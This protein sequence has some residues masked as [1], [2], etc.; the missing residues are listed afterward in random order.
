MAELLTDEII[1]EHL[2]NDDIM[3]EPDGPWI[4][5]YMQ[6]QYGGKLDNTSDFVDDKWTLKIYSEMTYDGYDI[7][8][9]TFED[10][11]Y[12]SQDGYYYED[13]SDWSS[14]AV[15]EL[16]GGSNV[17]IDPC[18]W[19]DM[20]Y[21]FNYELEQWWQ[22]IYDDLYDEKKEELLDSGEYYEEKED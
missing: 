18:L 10:K 11:P 12:V 19:S 2:E 1:I 21:E 16:T 9:C 15:E 17:W 4:L 6:E 5:E 3:Q 13:Y 22:D 8:W 14:R 20:E 7:F